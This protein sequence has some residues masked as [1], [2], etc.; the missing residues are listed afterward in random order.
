MHHEWWDGSGYPNGIRG[1]QIPLPCRIISVVD[2]Y[3]V[4]ITG[5]VY[6]PAR[7]QNEVVDE[8]RRCAGNT[9]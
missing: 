7:C 2:A 9:V 6:R 3:D 4:M 5:R 8:L 1:E